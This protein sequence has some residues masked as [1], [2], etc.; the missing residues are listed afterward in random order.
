MLNSW[1][2]MHKKYADL[3]DAIIEANVIKSMDIL[4]RSF[5]DCGDQLFEENVYATL[6]RVSGNAWLLYYNKEQRCSY[7]LFWLNDSGLLFSK[8]YNVKT[9]A[10]EICHITNYDSR[11]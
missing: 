2:F 7:G 8:I 11:S 4:L 9:R 6:T 10:W 3:E 5:A 1:L